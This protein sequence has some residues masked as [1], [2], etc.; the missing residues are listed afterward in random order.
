[1]G[2][3]GEGL[4]SMGE[5]LGRMGEGLGRMGEGNEVGR[6]RDWWGVCMERWVSGICGEDC[7]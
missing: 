2:R 6:V 7:L 5:G 4:G 1:M 3:V